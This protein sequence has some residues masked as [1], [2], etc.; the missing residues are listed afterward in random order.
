RSGPI[1]PRHLRLVAAFIG[2]QIGEST[3]SQAQ[4]APTVVSLGTCRLAGVATIQDCRIAYRAFGRLN[5]N[6]TNA[7][8]IPTWL[9][10]RSEDWLPLL[11]RD[12]YVD[13]TR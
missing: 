8:L 4:G 12:A 1:M 5:A 10:G 2:L 7:V 9:L 6:R 11:G 3:S 13:T